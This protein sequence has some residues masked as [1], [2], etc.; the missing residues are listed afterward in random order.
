MNR[1]K[2]EN[3]SWIY[4]VV[5]VLQNEFLTKIL[6]Y[7]PELTFHVMSIFDISSLRFR[8]F[9]TLLWA[10]KLLLI[11]YYK[12]KT[13]RK[14]YS[15]YLICSWSKMVESEYV[16]VNRFTWIKYNSIE[17]LIFN[18]SLLLETDITIL[19]ISLHLES[20][21]NCL[22]KSIHAWK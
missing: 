17:C 4:T 11:L 9:K 2:I 22:V 7:L 10:I 5:Y 6:K 13:V 19:A 16:W 21:L 1:W 18:S 8:H 14:I 15:W 3:D 12:P 20:V